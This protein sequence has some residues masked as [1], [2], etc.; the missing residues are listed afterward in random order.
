MTKEKSLSNIKKQIKSVS[1]SFTSNFLKKVR[2]FDKELED[3]L[4]DVQNSHLYRDDKLFVDLVP[5]YNTHKIKSEYLLLKD[6]SNFQLDDFINKHFLSTDASKNIHHSINKMEPRAYIKSLWGELERHT[7]Q[8]LGSLIALPNTYAVSGGRFNEQFYWD[9]YFIMLG[10]A[11]DNEWDLFENMMS[12]ITYM[13][14]KFGFVPTA[15]RTY[16]LTRSQ[17]PFFS[18]MVA[19]LAEHKG[20][21]V[22]PKY[23]PYLLSEH[24]FWMNG[25]DVLSSTNRQSISRVAKLPD[26][27]ILN[28]Y[29]DNL[30]DPR[31]ESI[32][33]DLQLVGEAGYRRS[34]SIFLNIRAAAESGWDFSSRWFKDEKDIH[35]IQ[36]VDIVPVD[37]NCLMFQLEDI[38]AQ[39]YVLLHQPIRAKDFRE[40]SNSRLNSLQKYCWNEDK[41]YFFDY[42][43]SEKIFMDRPSLAAVFPLYAK[44]ATSHQAKLVADRLEKDFLKV[45]G[46]ATTLVETGQ[47][48]DGSNGWAPLQWVAIVGLRNYGFNRLADE[49]KNRW[50]STNL[51]IFSKNNCFAEKYNVEK[52]SLLGGG[53][54][55]I[56]QLGF[57]WTNGVLAA[58]LQE[59][60]K[61]ASPGM[62]KN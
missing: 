58:L 47:Q 59:D 46:L 49:I 7:S 14:D 37:L 32:G 62:H 4:Y 50:I 23:L 9:S 15:N 55:Y 29:Y 2:G 60:A 25:R 19:L 27:S 33:A 39:V 20:E 51:K 41:G 53:G 38:I 10:L 56:I 13:I 8:S 28:R 36:T 40:L 45:G 24:E 6:D 22:M 43:F 48:W 30:K 57:G 17:P 35:T 34:D 11:A 21:N 61:S 12:N 52:P 42:N 1:K 18:R 31:P 3:L 16:F 26:G 44:I 5:R 54:E